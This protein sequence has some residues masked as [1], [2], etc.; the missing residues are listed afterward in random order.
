M[1]LPAGRLFNTR[2]CDWFSPRAKTALIVDGLARDEKG[3]RS[4]S[5]MGTGR[6]MGMASKCVRSEFGDS[7]KY[8]RPGT[9]AYPAANLVGW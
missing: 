2:G 5:E 3:A 7:S 1:L 8:P 4:Q 9:M 6:N